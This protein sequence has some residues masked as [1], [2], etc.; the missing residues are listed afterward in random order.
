M[1]VIR[2]GRK[3][4]YLPNYEFYLVEGLAPALRKV[5]AAVIT[6]AMVEE[7]LEEFYSQYNA[8]KDKVVEA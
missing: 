3:I 6:P 4:T 2:H 7:M 1:E 8:S 5:L